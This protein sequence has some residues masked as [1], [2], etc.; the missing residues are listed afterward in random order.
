MQQPNCILGKIIMK[1]CLQCNKEHN[2]KRFCSKRCSNRYRYSNGKVRYW[3]ENKC[4][5]CGKKL[6]YKKRT[7]CNNICKEEYRIFKCSLY[8]PTEE[9]Q[10][11]SCS[12][13]RQNKHI[14]EFVGG[15]SYLCNYCSSK[16]RKE[17]QREVKEMCVIYKGNRCE[18]CGYNKCNASLDFHHLD[19]SKKDFAISTIKAG[20]LTEKL[21]MELDK[22]ILICSNCHREYHF[23]NRMRAD[24]IDERKP[25][26]YEI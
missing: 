2:N 17:Y 25:P 10:Y 22:C 23:K 18:V 3:H 6:T 24:G 13:C 12:R 11:K 15:R 9:E 26:E 8:E 20:E 4:K 7:Y 5:R 1:L 19:P 14:S 21:K 16:Y